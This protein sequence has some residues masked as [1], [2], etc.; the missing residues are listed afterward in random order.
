VKTA[1]CYCSLALLVLALAVWP[2]IT[3]GGGPPVARA[4]ATC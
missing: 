3:Q 1:S 2:A 4:A